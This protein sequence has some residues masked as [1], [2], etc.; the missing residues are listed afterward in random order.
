MNT[1]MT[2]YDTLRDALKFMLGDAFDEK[3]PTYFMLGVLQVKVSAWKAR[4][5]ELENAQ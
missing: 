5:T 1:G 3:M 4:I 2:N